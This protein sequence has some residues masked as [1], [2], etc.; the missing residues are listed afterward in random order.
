EYG[1]EFTDI[2]RET[3]NL[4]YRLIPYIYTAMAEAS[5]SGI[6]AMRPMMFE[7]PEDPRFAE[8]ADEFM[9]GADLLVAPVITEGDRRRTVELP[10]GT[11]YDFISGTPLQGGTSVTVDAPLGRIPVFARAGSV[12]PTQQILQY[13]SQAPISPLTLNAFPPDSGSETVSPYYED[14]GISFDFARGAYYRR[15]FRQ[16]TAGGKRTLLIGPVE[17]SYHPSPRLICIRF[18]GCRT[19]PLE[20]RAGDRKLDRGSPSGIDAT[21][22]GFDMRDGAATVT[23]ADSPQAIEITLEQ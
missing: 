13:T 6:P 2:N 18:P 7:F 15:S 19:A 4:R 9:F 1:E 10:R 17:G 12:V 5:S 21:R 22:W 11:W 23:I 8:T 3:I 14:D 20:V 16:A